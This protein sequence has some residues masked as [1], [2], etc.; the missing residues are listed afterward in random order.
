[1]P[2]KGKYTE[3]LTDL[4]IIQLFDAGLYHCDLETGQIW[5]DRTDCEVFRFHGSKKSHQNFIRLYH[6]NK[7]RCYPVSRIIWIVGNRRAIPDGFE[8]HH[9]DLDN[10]NDAF[11]NLYAISNLDH[12]KL[13]GRDLLVGRQAGDEEDEWGTPLPFA[14]EQGTNSEPTP[15]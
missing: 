2:A 12:H 8:V 1:M 13:H 14:E 4:E 5:S 7:V 3:K 6:N 11:D 10:Q 9:R 15:F